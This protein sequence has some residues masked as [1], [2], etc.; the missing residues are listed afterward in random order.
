MGWEIERRFL[1]RVPDAVWFGLGEGHHFR[2]GYIRNGEP[3]V[4]IR[5]GE[6]RGAVL[7]FAA[8]G[9]VVTM[10]DTMAVGDDQRRAFV[11]IS[12][13]ECLDSVRVLGTEGDARHI[14]VTVVQGHQAQILLVDLLA[15]RRELGTR[16]EWRGL[17]RL[18][19]RVGIDLGI[20]HQDV[21][22]AI[23]RHDMVQTA[24]ADVISPAVA[25]DQPDALAYE[26]IRQQIETP[27]FASIPV[28]ASLGVSSICLEAG[29]PE[30][31]LEQ[32]D[33]SLYMAKRNGRNQVVCWQDLPDDVSFDDTILTR[34]FESA[35][36]HF[37]RHLH[38]ALAE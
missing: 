10:G 17:G 21:D 2:Q 9:Q 36:V 23:H 7:L 11:R 19:A 29:T 33:K 14:D 5:V 25:A 24:V 4:R 26:I 34:H 6:P 32:A 15:P 1:V 38:A 12:L 22:I 18:S 35:A 3:S 28:T 8:V 13:L 16:P 37:H 31:M 20:Q 27:G 30:E